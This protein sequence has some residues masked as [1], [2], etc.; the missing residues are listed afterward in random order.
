MPD[1]KRAL[2]SVGAGILIFVIGF[3]VILFIWKLLGSPLWMLT[4]IAW[5]LCWPFWLLTSVVH[6]PLAARANLA[7]ALCSGVLADVAILSG[8]VYAALSRFSRMSPR[9]S[10]PP[11]PVPFD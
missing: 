3:L 10:S 2:G 1:A 7:I 9:P 6:I 4:G 11:S 8:L 5:M